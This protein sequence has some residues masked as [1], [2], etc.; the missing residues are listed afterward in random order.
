[1]SKESDIARRITEFDWSVHQEWARMRIKTQLLRMELGAQNAKQ[2]R[3][4]VLNI[5]RDLEN[6]LRRWA[7]T[8]D[9]HRTVQKDLVT[10]QE[11]GVATYRVLA[12]EDEK[13]T[14]MCHTLDGQEFSIREA[15]IGINLPPFHFH[16]RCRIE[17]GGELVFA[18]VKMQPFFMHLQEQ[19]AFDNETIELM[20]KLKDA[21][22]AQYP[23]ATQMELDWRF[24][25]LL[26]GFVYDEQDSFRWNQVAAIALSRGMTEEEYFTNVLGFA[27][28]E[29]RRLRYMVRVQYQIVSEIAKRIP[30][31]EFFDSYMQNMSLAFG[32]NWDVRNFRDRV[33]FS[34]MWVRLYDSLQ[35]RGDFAH[36][37]ITMATHLATDLGNVSDF[38]RFLTGF[39]V[40][41]RNRIEWLA[42]WLG[43]ATIGDPPSFGADDYIADLDAANIVHIMRTQGLSFAE[44]ADLYYNQIIAERTRA[45]VFLEHTPFETVVSEIFREL[46]PIHPRQL[47]ELRRTL[48]PEEVFE[49]QMHEL[50]RIAIDAYWFIRSL[51]RNTHEMWRG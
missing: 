7:H 20:Q 14:D 26:G 10:L 33:E 28:G 43:D 15:R 5:G 35:G 11:I 23:D 34:R 3:E 1:M 37:M 39:F 27:E 12:E 42:G 29:F 6:S 45:E 25:R 19:F 47:V 18:K 17:R 38:G 51:E 22:Y 49:R 21:L 46:N 4:N 41:D 16:C 48:S 30:P 24:M 9:T 31:A 50:R 40:G 44:A 32:K 2:T 36:Q 13:T 8:L